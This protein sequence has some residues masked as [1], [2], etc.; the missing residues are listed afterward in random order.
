MQPDRVPVAAVIAAMSE[1]LSAFAALL[2]GVVI[3]DGPVGG[4]DEHHLIDVAGSVVALRRSGIGFTNATAAVAHCFH[5]FGSVPVISVGTAG[6]LMRDVEIG[7]VIVGDHYVNLNADATAFGYALGQ[8]PGMPPG[9]E[10]DAR[11][12]DVAAAAETA[13]PVRRATIG[14]SEVF[15][16]EGRARVLREAFPGV[17]AVDMESAAVAQFA[18]VHAMPFVSIRGISD[19]CAP[20]GEQFREHLDGAA[21]RA[22]RVAHDVVLGLAA[23]AR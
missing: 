15:V 12:V 21:D 3:D 22:A 14:S 1:E 10:P 5:D 8:V 19:L 11:M 9:Y 7:D 16:T 6:G 4:H 20:D 13:W 2:G 18:H 23:A 17:A